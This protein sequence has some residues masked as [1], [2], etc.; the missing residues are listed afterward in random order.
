MS[1]IA[2]NT[3]ATGLSALSTSLDVTAN[4]LANA[5]TTG[6]KSARVNFEDLYYQELAQPGIAGGNGI[7]R[8]TGLYVGLGTQTSGTQLNFAQGPT[9]TTNQPYDLLIEGD[10]FFQLELPDDIGEG[11][12]YTRAGNF[13]LNR[14][15]ELVLAN[16]AGFRLLGG[17]TIPEDATQ[18]SVSQ[19]GIVSGMLPGQNQPTEFGQLTLVRFI[20]PAGLR[21]AGG[22]VYLP[23]EASGDPLE[24]E[25]GSAGIGLI[26]QGALESSNVDPVT[27]LVT[28]IKTQRVFEMNS[29]VIQAANETLQN[30]SNIRAF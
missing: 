17:V 12:G 10:G 5:N 29:Q 23:T 30:I 26:R 4:N 25:P 19:D 3:A 14:D 1:Y 18:V 24:G 16:S 22:N 7:Q 2:L 15:G 9:E 27:E 13:T 28:L 11:I 20:N 21:S 6:F 8:P